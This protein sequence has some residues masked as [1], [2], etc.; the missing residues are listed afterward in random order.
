MALR[1]GILEKAAESQERLERE[2]RPHEQTASPVSGSR[3]DEAGLPQAFF[4]SA[5][6]IAASTPCWE[7][8]VLTFALFETERPRIADMYFPWRA[9]RGLV[10]FAI[11]RA[12]GAAVVFRVAVERADVLAVARD[13]LFLPDVW[14]VGV[15]EVSA[16]RSAESVE[17]SVS[18]SLEIGRATGPPK[19]RSLRRSCPGRPTMGEHPLA[20]IKGG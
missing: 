13:A 7:R 10:A 19:R 11:R 20:G 15:A 5:R 16:S 6:A 2:K 17:A 18:R 4:D 3:R 9:S 12:A 14:T 1:V 8:T